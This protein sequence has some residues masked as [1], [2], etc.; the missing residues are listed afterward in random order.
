MLS[1]IALAEDSNSSSTMIGQT[2]TDDPITYKIISDNEISILKWDNPF[3]FWQVEYPLIDDMLEYN[4]KRYSVVAVERGAFGGD[5]IN[6]VFLPRSV[7]EINGFYTF[8]NS[9]IRTVSMGNSITEIKENTF[10]ECKNLK[11]IFLSNNIKTIGD[12]A[13]QSCNLLKE[14]VLPATLEELGYSPFKWCYELEKVTVLAPVPPRLTGESLGGAVSFVYVP[15]ESIELYRNDAKWNKYKLLPLEKK[16][17]ETTYVETENPEDINTSDEYYFEKDDFLY[18]IISD[19]EVTIAAWRGTK[20]YEPEIKETIDYNGKFYILTGIEYR[21]FANTDVR[22]IVMPNSIRYIGEGAFM[23]SNLQDIVISEN[24][25]EIKSDTFK[26]CLKG[27]K[28]IKIPEG[29]TK[30]GDEVFWNATYLNNI[31]LPSTLTSFGYLVFNHIEGDRYVFHKDII[32]RA[33]TPPSV[34]KLFGLNFT[35]PILAG[36]MN[37]YVPEES[38]ELYRNTAPYSLFKNILP[39]EAANIDI[40]ESQPQPFGDIY[41]ISGRTVLRNAQEE[42]IQRLSRGIYI[43]NGKKI[44]VK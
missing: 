38:V 5:Y 42:D 31:D 40:V 27:F 23:D 7:R 26:R 41:D 24:V 36:E 14:I 3:A 33:S 10:Y 34:E 25:K 16:Q 13:F 11:E 15:E 17:D 6:D 29:V 18:H 2:F 30:I 37:L 43:M 4:G 1:G 8:R 21:A 39:I 19:S 12:Y 28:S 44:Y 22:K 32:I 9:Y 20:N 35:S